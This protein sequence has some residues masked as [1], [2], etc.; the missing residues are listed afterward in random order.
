ML[1][2]VCPKCNREVDP[3]YEECPFCK[4]APPVK[5]TAR[6]LKSARWKAWLGD[7]DR[8]FRFGLGFVVAVATMYFVLYLVAYYGGHEDWLDRLSRWFRLR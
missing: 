6:Q 8:G 2:W 7:V 3:G 1:E 5:P 4:P